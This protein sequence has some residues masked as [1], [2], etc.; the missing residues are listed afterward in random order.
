MELQSIALCSS[1][2]IFVIDSTLH[3]CWERRLDGHLNTCIYFLLWDQTSFV[4][5]EPTVLPVLTQ[6]RCEMELEYKLD[7]QKNHDAP[8]HFPAKFFITILKIFV[9]SSH[10]LVFSLDLLAHCLSHICLIC[11]IDHV[12]FKAIQDHNLNTVRDKIHHP[13]DFI[14]F[15]KHHQKASNSE[16]LQCKCHQVELSYCSWYQREELHPT[17]D[18][19]A[20]FNF[21]APTA[22]LHL[23]SL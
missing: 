18:Q 22:M 6:H 7:D 9:F 17:N 12:E 23:F 21:N 8:C 10:K 11:P 15:V 1:V 19:C 13:V 16:D 3:E 14:V 4:H 20:C 5:R 2:Q